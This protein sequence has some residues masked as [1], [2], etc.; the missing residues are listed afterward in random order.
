MIVEIALFIGCV[1]LLVLTT[2]EVR[3]Q[4]RQN[5]EL[6][7]TLAEARREKELAETQ[8]SQRDRQLKQTKDDFLSVAAHQLRTPLGGMK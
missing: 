4:A 8:H 6:A 7:D 2:R 3:H 5:R 1:V